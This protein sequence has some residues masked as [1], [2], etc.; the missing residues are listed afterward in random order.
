MTMTL[1][2]E[3]IIYILIYKYVKRERQNDVSVFTVIRFKFTCAAVCKAKVIYFIGLF[4][5]FKF[6]YM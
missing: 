6:Y 3:S 5:L 4:L 2:H 1:W